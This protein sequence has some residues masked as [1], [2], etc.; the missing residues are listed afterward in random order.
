MKNNSNNHKELTIIIIYVILIEKSIKKKTKKKL[1]Q[2]I[3][4]KF[5]QSDIE[6][7]LNKIIDIF[8]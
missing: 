7:K 5:R 4:I 3:K 6:I 1:N 8:F 2:T